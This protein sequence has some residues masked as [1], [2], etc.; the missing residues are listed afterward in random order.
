MNVIIDIPE[1]FFT[2]KELDQ[3]EKEVDQSGSS[4]YEVALRHYRQK[5]GFSKKRSLTLS[6]IKRTFE[7]IRHSLDED[8][9]FSFI[10]IKQKPNE[11]GELTRQSFSWAE[12]PERFLTNI[13]L[14]NP[15]EVINFYNNILDKLPTEK[16]NGPK[17]LGFDNGKIYEKSSGKMKAYLASFNKA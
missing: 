12:I 15:Q 17:I 4:Y 8:I 3:I 7:K 1:D 14:K 2:D 10:G 16:V 5:G 9:I 6:E 13:N 11:N